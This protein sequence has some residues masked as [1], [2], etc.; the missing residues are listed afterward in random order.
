MANKLDNLRPA[1]Q[2]GQS[3]NIKGRKVG[4]RNRSTIIKELLMQGDNELQMHLAQLAKAIE[5]GDTNAYKA[6]LESAYG[7]PVQTIEVNNTTN[8]PDWMDEGKS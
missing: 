4:T 2:K 6:I 8:Y 7:A 1:W 5:K 3:G